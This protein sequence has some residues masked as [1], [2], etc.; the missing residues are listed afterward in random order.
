[1]TGPQQRTPPLDLFRRGDSYHGVLEM[2]GVPAGCISVHVS[3]HEVTV[4]ADRKDATSQADEV[5][6]EER[7]HGGF[8]RRFRLPDD[9][10]PS[11]ATAD[12]T[13]GLLHVAASCVKRGHAM[14]DVDLDIQV[15]SGGT[16][17]APA[18]DRVARLR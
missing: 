18:E 1:M 12:S 2:P 4:T 6:V 8:Q 9:C 5:L 17:L 16:H 11:T 13:D 7:E 3:G 15:D 14:E 10:D